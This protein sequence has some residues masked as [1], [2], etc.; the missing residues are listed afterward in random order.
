MDR[1]EGLETEPSALFERTI[2]LIGDVTCSAGFQDRPPL[3]RLASW[4]PSRRRRQK[5]DESPPTANIRLQTP[6][7]S[8]LARFRALC[9][10]DPPIQGLPD[11]PGHPDVRRLR[12][13]RTYSSAQPPQIH[14]AIIKPVDNVTRH[15]RPFVRLP[16]TASIGLGED[17]V[18]RPSYRRLSEGV[19]HR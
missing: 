17:R 5:P 13:N 1:S 10:V 12:A 6:I 19:S 14:H 2:V 8:R 7:D 16:K 18:Q 15:R 3:A 9:P 11:D 4:P